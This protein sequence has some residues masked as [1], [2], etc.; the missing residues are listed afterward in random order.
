MDE[1]QL[2][3]LTWALKV[4]RSDPPAID[5]ATADAH[6]AGLLQGADPKIAREIVPVFMR[7]T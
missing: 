6:R 7:T 3:V 1:R 2:D 4:L 5:P